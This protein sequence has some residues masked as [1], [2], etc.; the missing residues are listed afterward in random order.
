[1]KNVLARPFEPIE[2]L[3]PDLPPELAQLITRMVSRERA[4]RPADLREVM[5]VLEQ[6]TE[7]RAPEFAPPSKPATAEADQPTLP[8]GEVDALRTTQPG[9]A[10]AVRRERRERRERPERSER[11]E[12]SERRPAPRPEPRPAPPRRSRRWLAALAALAAIGA[13]VAGWRRTRSPVPAP[14]PHALLAAPGAVLACPVLE[15]AGVDEPAGWLGA[16]AAATA[17]ERARV[18]LGGRPERTLVPAELLGL[19]RRPVDGFPADPYATADARPRSLDAARRRATAYLDGAVTRHALGFRVALVLRAAD[20]GELGRGEASEPGLHDAVRAAMAPL[21]RADRLPPAAQL[22]PELAGWARTRDP[23]AALAL[24]D[25]NLAMAQNAGGVARECDRLAQQIARIGGLGPTWRWLCA[26]TLGMAAPDVPLDASDGSPEATATRIWIEHVVRRIDPP[27]AAEQ[28]HRALEGSTTSWGRSLLAAIESCLVQSTAPDR[29]YDLAIAAVTAEPKNPDGQPCDPWSQLM[30]VTQH[31]AIAG[32]ATL[33]M[34]AWQPWSGLGLLMQGLAEPDPTAALAP[35]RRAHELSPFDS[36]IAGALAD[37]LLAAGK[38]ND[39]DRIAR[40]QRAG[41]NRVNQ[42]EGALLGVRIAASE[43]QLAGA[44]ALARTTSELARDDSGWV[45]AE[46]F[47]AAWRALELAG[48]LGRARELADA[49][50]ERFLD[51]EQPA[52]DAAALPV[53]ARVAALCALASP[54][55]APHCFARFRELRGRLSGAITPETDDLL[56][57]A[58]R[59]AQRD[60]AGAARAWRP[61]LRNAPALA[62]VLPDAMVEVF[63][64]TGNP[65]LAARVDDAVMLRAGEFGGATPGHARAARRALARGDRATARALAD[66]VIAAWQFADETPPAFADMHRLLAQLGAR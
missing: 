40:D 34:Q 48:I 63:T 35:L 41:A 21:I 46:R 26:R 6:L 20:G 56:R 8:P 32:A 57:G 66:Q 50:V 29:A 13:A 64:A 43:A 11:S 65:E 54:A 5:A 14:A 36:Q 45:R 12:R 30:T 18:I 49:L 22:D 51:P 23:A 31:K 24:L 10:L 55:V 27:G 2:Q 61:L 9:I 58:E 44:L 7:A 19:P 39:A 28:V 4:D 59:Y 17:C 37:R 38:R 33:A 25:V 53:Q 1:L 15:A 47:E 3:V 42:V 62:A 60:A 16:A 52:L